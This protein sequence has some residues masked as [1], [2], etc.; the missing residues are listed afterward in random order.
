VKLVDIAGPKRR[1]Y[2]QVTFAELETKS[3]II[4]KVRDF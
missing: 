2:L 3:K 1:K 4:K